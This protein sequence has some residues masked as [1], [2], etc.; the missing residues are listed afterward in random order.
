MRVTSL[1]SYQHLKVQVAFNQERLNNLL[2]SGMTFTAATPRQDLGFVNDDN[3]GR[4]QI[5]GDLIY[6]LNHNGTPGAI[7]LEFWRPV[8]QVEVRVEDVLN[9]GTFYYLKRNWQPGLTG[10][11]LYGATSW[12]TTQAIT[13]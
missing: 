3:N 11:Q 4:L 9:P 7:A 10:A 1:T 6:Q 5:I 12:T 8:W 2:A 13:I